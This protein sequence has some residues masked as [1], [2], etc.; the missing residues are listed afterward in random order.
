MYGY[1]NDPIADA[2][3]HDAELQRALDRLPRC[4]YCGD[5]I[6]DDECYEINDSLICPAC[7][8]EYHKKR[9]DD[10]IE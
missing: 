1:T 7:L 9:T 2:M 3:R 10:Y 6:Q 5:P 4:A 8:E